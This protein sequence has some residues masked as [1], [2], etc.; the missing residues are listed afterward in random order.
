MQIG[1]E[2][3]AEIGLFMYFQDG[4]RPPSWICFT[5]ILNQPRRSLDGLYFPWH[6]DP[7]GCD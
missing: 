1:L 5:P 3:A 4:G 6:N 7:F 2:I